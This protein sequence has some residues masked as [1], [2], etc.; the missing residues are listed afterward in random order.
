MR[1]AQFDEGDLYVMINSHDQPLRFRIQ[2][3]SADEWERVLDTSLPSPED[4]AEP[5]HERAI[6]SLEYE[7]GPRS[8]VV[9]A[10]R[11]ARLPD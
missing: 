3:R 8:V 6:Q 9:L 7:V 2:E 4:I 1:G 5:G 10:Q 11:V